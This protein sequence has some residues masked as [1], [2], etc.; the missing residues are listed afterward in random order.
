ML[1]KQVAIYLHSKM[2]TIFDYIV[3]NLDWPQL[4]WF[5]E[6]LVSQCRV[7]WPSLLL[8]PRVRHACLPKI[9]C[10]DG[11]VV[12]M[13]NRSIYGRGM[14]DLGRKALRGSLVGQWTRASG[15]RGIPG[16]VWHQQLPKCPYQHISYSISITLLLMNATLCT[17]MIY[18][19]HYN[20]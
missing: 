12:N 3:V 18:N 13:P 19:I 11:Y 9:V 7:G 10:A 4:V 14:Q 6:W 15:T 16:T 5:T 2:K 17:Y 1:S 8:S 20:K